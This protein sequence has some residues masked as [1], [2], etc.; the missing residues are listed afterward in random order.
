[1]KKLYFI[2]YEKFQPRLYQEMIASTAVQ[3]NTLCI[4]PTGLGKTYIAILVAA[5]ILEN[6][7]NSKVL[8][9]APTRPLVQQHLKTF[10]SIM[11]LDKHLFVAL[12][13]RI[14]QE[15]RRIF[16]ENSRVFFATPQIIKNDVDSGIL[17]LSKF[18]LLIVDECHRSVKKY[19][20]TEVAE[21]YFSQSL[22]PLVLG[23]T[24]SPG[25]M[26]DKIE[27]VKKKLRIETIEVRTEKD[28]DVKPYVKETEIEKIYIEMPE[29]F[30]WI[31]AMLED[32]YKEKLSE[33]V[34]VNLLFSM[35]VSKKELLDVQKKLGEMYNDTRDGKVAKY[36]VIASQAIKVEHAINL[37]ET[38]GIF[39]L[40]KYFLDLKK[41]KSSST[42]GMINDKRIVNA[43]AKI[44]ELYLKGFE[45]PKMTKLIDIIKEEI[46]KKKNTKIIV[47]ANYRDTV[48][49]I[50]AYL[51]K[52]GI[53]AREFIGQA[54][55]GGK[56][57][58][59]KDQVKLI[60]E[61]EYE[62]FNVLIA[63]SIGEE[64][65]SIPAVDIVIFYEPVP[66]EIRTIQRRGRTGR[67]ESGR[68]IFLITKGTRDE[69]YYWSAFHKEKRM[70]NIIS[71][72]KSKI[73]NNN[74][75][76]FGVS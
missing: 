7:P 40:H 45:H 6:K 21:R 71:D 2:D 26:Q 23:L 48:S 43:F 13:G 74:I 25:G 9:I 61:F 32:Y 28:F 17:D 62:L 16:Y 11:T 68:V 18:Y 5:W 47:F 24:A 3:R 42:R 58:S 52:N 56:G 46:E 41:N 57:L 15:D 54:K 75:K 49:Q 64:G 65:L 10:T 19:A 50:K 29:E 38:Q 67:T 59:Q 4:L 35:R 31:R 33:L 27:E 60:N 51:D 20:Y 30:R 76:D 70:K 69:W 12:T 55:K 39:P 1:M 36:L 63:T 44:N 8:M 14:K 34:S 53:E 37:L 22:E 72:L 66:S 73:S